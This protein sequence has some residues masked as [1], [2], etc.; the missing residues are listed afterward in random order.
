MN[1]IFDNWWPGGCCIQEKIKESIHET[2]TLFWVDTWIG[3]D[4]LKVQY[5]NLYVLA[6][7][8]KAK[9]KEVYK[10]INGGTF[11]DWEWTR[12]P[13]TDV[14]KQEMESL[15]EQL[16][17]QKMSHVGDVWVWKNYEHQEFSVKNVK[18]SLGRNLDLN[19][20][21]STFCWNSWATGNSAAFVWRAMDNK[22][23][24]AVALRD[25]GVNLQE[26][27]CKIC[28]AGDESAEHIL[29]HCNL[30]A[31]VWEAVKDWTKTRWVNTNGSIAELLQSIL[32][33]QMG[34]HRRKMLHTI[35]IQ[36]MWILWKNRNEKVFTGKLKPAQIIIEDIKDTSFQGVKLRSKYSSITK[37]QWWDFNFI[38]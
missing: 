26:V 28:G 33:G 3:N 36:A 18:L 23:P 24:S 4:P 5:P 27:S 9:I 30:A 6:A 25:R 21:P 2:K 12:A 10:D 34:S 29:L 15:K 19:S 1:G 14:E 35:A 13:N 8:K 20:S 38:L 17:Q 16:Q 22:I 31:R 7:K 32:D 11:W 37:Q